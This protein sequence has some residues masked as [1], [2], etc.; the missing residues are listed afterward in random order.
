MGTVVKAVVMMVVVGV[1]VLMTVVVVK[2]TRQYHEQGMDLDG[3]N[4]QYDNCVA[5]FDDFPVRANDHTYLG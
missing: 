5:K 2:V 1:A 3:S 4:Y